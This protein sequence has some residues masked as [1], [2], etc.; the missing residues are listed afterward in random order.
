MHDGVVGERKDQ[1]HTLRRHAS[2]G[3]NW[4]CIL[5]NYWRQHKQNAGCFYL[6]NVPFALK[7]SLLGTQKTVGNFI[8][9]SP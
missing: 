8:D 9:H 1:L 3:Q 5:Q 4:Q 2:P 6:S 7:A